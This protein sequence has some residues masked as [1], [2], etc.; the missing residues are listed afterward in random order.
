MECAY[1]RNKT[2]D[3][4][5]EKLEVVLDAIDNIIAC[6]GCKTVHKIKEEEKHE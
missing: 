4:S 1:W 6:P 5:A 2:K 3:F